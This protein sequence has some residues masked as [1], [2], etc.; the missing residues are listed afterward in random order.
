MQARPLGFALNHWRARFIPRVEATTRLD[1]RR[2]TRRGTKTNRSF[3]Q[4]PGRFRVCL[5]LGY[6]VTGDFPGKVVDFMICPASYSG[7]A[8]N[9]EA[10]TARS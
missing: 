10:H 3:R 8:T 7:V 4:H 2:C 1:R 9:L 6:I 5:L